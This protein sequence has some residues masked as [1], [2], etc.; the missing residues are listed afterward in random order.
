[1][2]EPITMATVAAVAEAGAA[3]GEGAAAAAGAAGTAEVGG[4]LAAVGEAAR[5]ASV[6]GTTE[7]FVGTLKMDASAVGET[8][9][10]RAETSGPALS[11]ALGRSTSVELGR[12]GVARSLETPAS[13][14]TFDAGRWTD[15]QPASGERVGPQ[16]IAERFRPLR[17]AGNLE[18]YAKHLEQ[19][20]S[21]FGQEVARRSQQFREASTPAERD[22]A[23]Q[24]LR[25]STAGKLGESIATDGLKPFF[26]KLE[27]QRR[28][29]T[30]NGMTFVDGRFTGARNPMVFGRGHGVSEGGSL[31]IEVKTGQPTYLEREVRHISERQVQ[32]HLAAGDRSLVLVSRD[33][34]AMSGERAAR[35]T[36]AEAGS[37]VMALLPEKR[38]MDESLVRLLRDRM[39][40]A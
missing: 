21:G 1:M 3:A 39:E 4:H 10:S 11:E 6:G 30:P 7:A 18:S 37:H 22:A 13:G 40:R 15:W 9:L 25:R 38:V 16:S 17:D 12:S 34:Y 14:S 2:P 8:M 32:G 36:V 20:D 28:V 19:R 27:L 33:V 35:D 24:Q 5:T 29:E 31:S 23:L 26:E